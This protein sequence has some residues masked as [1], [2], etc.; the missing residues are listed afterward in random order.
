MGEKRATESYDEKIMVAYNTMKKQG[1]AS[2]FGLGTVMLTVFGSYGLAVW[3]G[4]KL[5]IEE[6]YKGGQVMTV[7]FSIMNGG[8]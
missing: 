1:L 2:G 5:I 4:S 6:G 3:Y 7:I 8:M